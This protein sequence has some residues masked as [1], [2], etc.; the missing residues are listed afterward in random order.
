MQKQRACLDHISYSIKTSKW[1]KVF[2]GEGSF[3]N[4]APSESFL[5]AK[6]SSG[7]KTTKLCDST[8]KSNVGS[9]EK[10]IRR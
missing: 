1:I 4:V 2:Q 3:M 8:I 7:K 5:L 10:E 9:T 6:K